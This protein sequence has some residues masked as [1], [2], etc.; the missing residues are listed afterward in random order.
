MLYRFHI[1]LQ[2]GKQQQRETKPKRTEERKKAK[3]R[4]SL[5]NRDRCSTHVQTPG[6]QSPMQRTARCW[7][8][9]TAEEHSLIQTSQ[10]L[11]AN[12]WEIPGLSQPAKTLG[13][14]IQR[15]FNRQQHLLVLLL[16]SERHAGI[17]CLLGGLHDLLAQNPAIVRC[18][19]SAWNLQ[20]KTLMGSK[21]CKWRKN[22]E[23]IE[24]HKL[25]C[26]WLRISLAN[27]KGS[28]LNSVQSFLALRVDEVACRLLLAQVRCIFLTFSIRGQLR[29]TT[30]ISLRLLR[31][32]APRGNS[33]L[34]V[35]LIDRRLTYS[36]MRAGAVLRSLLR[37]SSLYLPGTETTSLL[38]LDQAIARKKHGPSLSVCLYVYLC[39]CVCVC[40][41][42][43]VSLSPV[44]MRPKNTLHGRLTYH[45]L[46]D[47]CRMWSQVSRHQQ[48]P[49]LNP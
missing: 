1:W 34:S 28:N 39:V 22:L 44:A 42:V 21:S 3:L 45:A 10:G 30:T 19:I 27:G 9:K 38:I 12:S 48:L 40:V 18:T 7:R 29:T 46:S 24:K 14:A 4:N 25:P 20:K 36:P 16:S 15:T 32:F 47:A 8:D 35:L 6:L 23:T 13:I 37:K 5:N 33:A 26:L 31:M 43:V 17:L 2:I 41:Y 49:H 11:Q